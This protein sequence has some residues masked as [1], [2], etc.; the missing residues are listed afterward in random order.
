M[1]GS[2]AVV[3]AVAGGGAGAGPPVLAGERGQGCRD[4]A[5]AG[6]YMMSLVAG[7]LPV[8][9]GTAAGWDAYRS[10]T[11]RT[12][13][14]P[15]V[16]CA[17]VLAEAAA[18]AE[19]VC[20]LRM[21]WS[22][23]R[24]SCRRLWSQPLEDGWERLWPLHVVGSWRAGWVPEAWQAAHGVVAWVWGVGER[25]LAGRGQGPQ[26]VRSWESSC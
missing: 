4:P 24:C 11:C 17:A 8:P 1:P 10:R 6:T 9:C 12:S 2:A 15:G 16:A 3:V 20:C 18:A 22:P 7:G 13:W 19:G 26:M 14:Q 5:M 21:S 23:S 25:Q